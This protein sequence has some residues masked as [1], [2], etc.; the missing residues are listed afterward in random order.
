MKKYI[1]CGGRQCA[2]VSMRNFVFP[3]KEKL[4]VEEI[5]RE[6]EVVV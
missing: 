4:N 3:F 5:E 6:K 1:F 2:S